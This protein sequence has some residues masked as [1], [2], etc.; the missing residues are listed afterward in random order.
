MKLKKHCFSVVALLLCTITFAQEETHQDKKIEVLDEVVVTD[1]RFELKRENSGKTVIKITAEE[2]QKSQGKTLAEVINTKSGIEINGSRS[3]AG[4]N[5]SYFV[6]GGNNRQVL[7]LID[8]VAVA[9]PS[10]IA[11]DFDLRL[12][13]LAQIESIEISKGAAS[14]LYGSGATTAVINITTKKASAKEI[15]A[16]FQSSIGTNQSQEGENDKFSDFSNSI[17]LN[18]RLGKFSYVAGFGNAYVNGL[19]AV[20]SPTNESDPFSKIN[21]N[22]KLGYDFSDSFSFQLYGNENKYKTGFDNTFPL[23]DANFT[24]ASEQYR[25]GAN[26]I[27]T[28]VDGSITLNTAYQTIDRVITSNFPSTFE[29]KTYVLDMFTRNTFAAQLHTIVGLNYNKSEALFAEASDFSI[30][31]P[32][33]NAVWVSDFGLNL[34]AGVRL[35]NHSEYGLHFTYNFNPSYTYI[36]DE[37]YVKLF[38]SYST[39]YIVPSLSQLFGF[40][41]PNPNLE[42]E[43]NTTFEG[44]FELKLT[45]KLRFSGLYFNRKEENFIAYVLVNPDIF[46][47]QY[48]NVS[49]NFKVQGVEIEVDAKPFKNATVTANYTFTERKNTTS[50][51]IPKHKINASFEH[52]FSQKTFGSLAF[53]YVGK[54]TD[55]NFSTFPFQ[56]EALQSF[57]LL[58]VYFSHQL[59]YNLKVFANITNIL[60][61]DYTEVI[62]FSTRGINFRVGFNLTL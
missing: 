52:D 16:T 41:G 24:S 44:G 14:T 19:S 3:N 38:G 28:Y 53:Q 1:S 32:Y 35:N 34:N 49:E 46:Q 40:F 33:L 29:G 59:K 6:R 57:S 27:F 56:D 30:V 45:D 42:P 25:V 61:E 17:G 5:L 10:Q 55:T 22:V 7:I 62:G 20:V 2:L 21:T 54:R 51:R 26:A 9:D 11:N 15:S 39:S 8:G 48:S 58:D 60:N 47:Y 13:S 37:H 43:E 31:D 23:E 4:Q 50:L 12:L 36:F 18:G